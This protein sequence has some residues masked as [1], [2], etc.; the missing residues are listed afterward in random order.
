MRHR[1]TGSLVYELPFGPGQA[2]GG[3]A[4]G[5]LAHLIGGWRMASIAT[6]RSGYPFTVFALGDPAD[7]GSGGIR[8]NLVGDPTIADPTIER[9]FDTDAFANPVGDFGDLGRNTMIGPSFKNVDLS[10]IKSVSLGATRQLEFRAEFFNLFNHTNF[11]IPSNVVDSATFGEL[12]SA[13]SARDIQLG[14]KFIF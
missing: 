10:I 3:G 7:V 14:L 12:T 4:T 2:F 8:A 5:P 1:F 9:F 11:G 13:S 6:L